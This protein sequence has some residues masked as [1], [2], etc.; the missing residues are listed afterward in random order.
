MGIAT[1]AK[2]PQLEGEH[3]SRNP[4]VDSTRSFVEL[5]NQNLPF[6]NLALSRWSN[7]LANEILA[8]ITKVREDAHEA[9]RMPQER[10]DM[11]EVAD[12]LS[13]VEEGDED[14]LK[15]NL[16]QRKWDS[17]KNLLDA[18]QSN[19]VL[20]DQ[21]QIVLDGLKAEMEAAGFQKV[22]FSFDEKEY[23]VPGTSYN[24]PS[25][26]RK[27]PVLNVSFELP[28]LDSGTP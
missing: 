12:A 10:V 4:F 2:R 11:V 3:A 18:R 16:R 1:S 15:A 19:V 13:F 24:S 21:I 14:D 25:Y 26:K 17:T 9:K 7:G 5:R 28:S 20:R 6:Q 27:R 8:H 23:V 22:S